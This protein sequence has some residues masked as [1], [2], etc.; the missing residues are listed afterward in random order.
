LPASRGGNITGVANA[1]TVNFC[2]VFG[3]SPGAGVLAKT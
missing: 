1:K 3:C 2:F